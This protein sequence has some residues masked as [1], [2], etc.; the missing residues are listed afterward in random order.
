MDSGGWKRFL[1][2]ECLLYLSF[3]GMDL[4]GFG[5]T[6]ALKY[7]SIL[8]IAGM[9]LPHLRAARP[10]AVAIALV[11]T[12][13]AD[14]FLL[15]LDRWYAAGILL[16]W[17]VQLC[18]AYR[19]DGKTGLMFRGLAA[20][21]A[22]ALLYRSGSIPALAAGYIAMFF[23]NLLRAAAAA[24]R[25]R[26]RSDRLLALGLA[27]FFCCDLCV[28]YF[29]IGEGPLWEFAR[30]AMWGFYLPGQ[31]LILASIQFKEESEHEA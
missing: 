13:L 25:S 28:G 24:R 30:V 7:L 29:H 15:V 16:V 11:F 14:L 10:R 12:A 27:L 2:V 9:A 19:L 6:T 18:Y 5:E 3:L 4:T 1:T 21:A 26:R 23:V 31:V 22:S 8:L 20:L 17:L